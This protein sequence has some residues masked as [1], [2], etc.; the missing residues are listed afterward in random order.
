MTIHPIF[1]PDKLRC[2]AN[3]PLPGQVI[4]TPEL[5]VVGDEQEWEVEEVLASQYTVDDCS[6][7]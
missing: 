3:D 2:A 6:I 7:R 4:E 5:I 1:S